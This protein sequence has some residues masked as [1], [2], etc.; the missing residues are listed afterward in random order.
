MT[1]TQFYKSFYFKLYSYTSMRHTDWFKDNGSPTHYLARMVSGN[2]KLS[3]ADYT[4]EL[5]AGDVFYIPKGEWYRSYWYPDESGEVSFYSFGFDLLPS[6]E[7]SGYKLQ[8]IECKAEELEMLLALEENITISLSSIGRL[9]TFLGA[10]S[11]RLEQ[12]EISKSDATV[13]K[14]LEFMRGN[15]NYSIGDVAHYCGVSESGL[16]VKFRNSV[17][18]TPLEMR[19]K[20]TINRAK[21][22]LATTDMS[23]EEISESLEFSSS[24]YFRKVFREHTGKTPS[25]VRKSSKTI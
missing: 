10:V 3:T 5:S 9:Y 7:T 13:L 11:D 8:K 18:K 20:I 25:Q 14:A 19:Q 1:D 24:S 23:V 6:R 12:K 2:A 16:Y 4:I 21:E 15:T 22:L 17:G